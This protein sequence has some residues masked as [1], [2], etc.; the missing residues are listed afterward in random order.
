MTQELEQISSCMFNNQVPPAW[1]LVG[2]LSMKPLASWIN[3]CNERI[4]F[5][6][7]W[8]AGGT[9]IKFWMSGFFFPQAFLTGTLQNFA[10]KNK[11]PIDR[12]AFNYNI[13]DHMTHEDIKE[14]PADGV[15][16]FGLFLEGCKWDYKLHHLGDSDPKKLFQELPLLHL[17]PMIDRVKPTEGIYITPTY[18]VLSRQGTLSTTGHST[19]FVINLELPSNDTQQK[20]ILAGVACFLALRF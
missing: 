9:P 13:A 12:V 3:D 17:V 1:A 4:D 8:I 15:F 16:V 20:W 18:R 7:V 11:V 14:K 10:R 19:N 6:D 2:F 5:L